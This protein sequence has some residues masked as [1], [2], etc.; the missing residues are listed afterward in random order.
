MVR[1]EELEKRQCSCHKVG[2][3]WIC[4]GRLCPKDFI[5]E[6]D[7]VKRGELE[8][9]QCS[10]RKIGDEWICSGRLCPS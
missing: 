1:R 9:R 7:M 2:D 4:S 6:G 8:K 5:P 3:E 10:C